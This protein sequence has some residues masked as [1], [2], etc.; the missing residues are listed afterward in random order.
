ME[1]YG[2]I[3]N[4]GRRE[5]ASLVLDSEGNPRIDTIRP[6]PLP[7]D[8]VDPQLLPVIKIEKPSQG[9]WNPIVIWLEDSVER[10]W[11]QAE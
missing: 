7:E 2:L 1:T 3:Y 4:D 5:L 11:E 10:R 9:N 6:Y 8:W